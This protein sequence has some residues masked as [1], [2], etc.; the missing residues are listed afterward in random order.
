MFRPT[1]SSLLFAGKCFFAALLQLQTGLPFASHALLLVEYVG[2]AWLHSDLFIRRLPRWV[3]LA[4]LWGEPFLI[5]L[6]HLRWESDLVL[7]LYLL[8]LGS[9]SLRL[10]RST[11][12]VTALVGLAAFSGGRYVYA[13]LGFLT[14]GMVQYALGFGLVALLGN[15]LGESE[16]I[17]QLNRRLQRFNE[18]LEE[19]VD[20][21]TRE[22]RNT[23]E[24]LILEQR[25]EVMRR[26]AALLAHELRQPLG[27]INLAAFF[28]R[29]R[30]RGVRAQHQLDV[31]EESV[32]RSDRLISTLLEYTQ[33][34]RP[35]P[36]QEDLV[37]LVGHA[38]RTVDGLRQRMQVASEGETVA[39]CDAGHTTIALG[40]VL[41]NAYQAVE[42]QEQADGRVEVRVAALNGHVQVSVRDNGPGIAESEQQQVWDPLYTTKVKGFGL[43]LP[44]AR[45]LVQ[46]Q[47]GRIELE[48]QPG[49]G[50]R[51]VVSL[52]RAEGER[53]LLEEIQAATREAAPAPQPPAAS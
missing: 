31:I 29:K 8:W 38:A 26:F 45:V 14:P 48:S 43:G 41:L 17:S 4:A 15:A 32:V 33:M 52:P 36:R 24:R 21:R 42:E 44:V 20:R 11:S 10:D 46:R 51:V 7:P 50:T 28:L 6:L 5:L 35:Q 18:E 49:Q 22:L 27:T 30:V 39:W 1:Y 40:H 3:S 9:A 13:G 16:L 12:L 47:G 25:E 19:E 23:Q 53:E 2:L 34:K 37:H